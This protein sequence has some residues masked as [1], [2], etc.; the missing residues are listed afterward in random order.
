MSEPK[1]DTKTEPEVDVSKVIMSSIINI[2]PQPDN[3][4]EV[5]LSLSKL[6]NEIIKVKGDFSVHKIVVDETKIYVYI[7]IPK[8]LFGELQSII[9]DTQTRMTIL[10]KSIVAMIGDL[11][12]IGR[13]KDIVQQ[14]DD[15]IIVI[16]INTSIIP[17]TPGVPN[18]PTW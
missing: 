5:Y 3:T 1:T 12:H 11:R 14:N 16:S 13:V 7:N 9:E 6:F 4:T 17:T 10:K 18:E 8:S 15:G 2:K